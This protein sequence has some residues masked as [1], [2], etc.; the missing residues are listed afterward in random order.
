MKIR[1]AKPSDAKQITSIW[2]DM[3]IQHAAYKDPY[4][5]RLAKDCDKVYIKFMKKSAKSQK[6]I[7]IVAE[8]GDKMVGFAQG[9]VSKKPPIFAGEEKISMLED[10]AVKKGH[11]GGGVGTALVREF[12]KMSKAKGARTMQLD[13][14]VQNPRALRLYRRLGFKPRMIK[15][16]KVLQ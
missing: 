12:S 14:H 6:R 11:R 4:F 15:L 13:V 3:L 16:I 9:E 1:A 8:D 10:V 5:S 2:H 7:V